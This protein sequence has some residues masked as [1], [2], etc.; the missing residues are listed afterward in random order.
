M[1]Y[2]IDYENIGMA[3]LNGLD[4][5]PESD[6][7]IVFFNDNNSKIQMDALCN[8]K[9]SIKYCKTP[10]GNQALDKYLIQ[11][12]GYLIGTKA[13]EKYT[14]I[15][16]DSGYEKSVELTKL[17][18]SKVIVLTGRSIAH[19]NKKREKLN[20][21]KETGKKAERQ[22]KPS[23][24]PLFIKLRNA[25]VEEDLANR[26]DKLNKEKKG[27]KGQ[28]KSDSYSLL[29]ERYGQKNGLRIYNKAKKYFN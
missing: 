5:L 28:F 9:C 11:Y 4:T 13:S 20:Q 22:L 3:G 12:L 27:R 10:C 26:I 18:D 8:V 6:T 15:S 7:V 14:I 24:S 1:I 17:I 29:I 16:N 25:G 2:L 23:E 19:P 21:E